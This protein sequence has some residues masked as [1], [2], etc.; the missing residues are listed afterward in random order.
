MRLV[1]SFE[2]AER[3]GTYVILVTHRIDWSAEVIL[4]TYLLR[5]PIETFYQ[6]GKGHLG[7]DEYRMRNA[8]A[9]QKH[10]CLVF[11]AYSFL[12]LECLQSSFDP[13]SAL[14]RKTIGEACRQQAAALIQSLIL[15]VHHALSNGESIENI[16]HRLFAKQ[17]AQFSI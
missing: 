17:S 7:L 3:T 2:N 11:V 14:L 8:E 16:F 10:W 12:H 9:F 13:K 15:S 4:N 1:I 6:D 5:W